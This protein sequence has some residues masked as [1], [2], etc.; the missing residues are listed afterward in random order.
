[1]PVY[2]SADLKDD[3]L[4]RKK[5]ADDAK[6][7]RGEEFKLGAPKTFGHIA[8]KSLKVNEDKLSGL[9]ALG[10]LKADVDNLGLLMS[11][12]LKGELST[13]S[14]VATLS[15]QINYYF[16]IYLPYLLM[17]EPEFNDVYTVFAGG[18]DLFL[19]GPW[20]RIIT[21]S[22]RINTSFSEYVC[23]NLNIHL[24]AGI[25]VH[26]PNTPMGFMA[27]SAESGLEEAKEHCKN[28]LTVFDETVLWDEMAKL[29]AIQDE[30]K[31]WLDKRWINAAM[32]YRLN[33]IIE[34]AG[35]E[36][37]IVANKNEIYLEDMECTK[38][39][40]LLSYSVGRNAAKDLKPEERP[41][42][43]DTVIKSLNN[44]LS[45]YGSKLKIPVWNMLYN[46]RTTKKITGGRSMAKVDFWKDDKKESIDP[47]LFSSKAEN[48]A[49][50]IKKES[51]QYKN[52]NKRTQIRK[53]YD[54]VVRLDVE[55][56]AREKEWHNIAPLVHMLTAKAAY[57]KGRNLISQG[58]S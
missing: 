10:V 16:S 7:E 42:V 38:W 56:K 6:L 3:R 17:T 47:T 45:E 18:D 44:W 14:R 58:F 36:N 43:I 23:K 34:M 46:R 26:K 21:L 37:R 1:M 29:T 9:E 40:A 49:L 13:L 15:R 48:L 39:R 22:E 20:N 50:E 41:A 5:A 8:G 57:A 51:E 53:F 32:L 28:R 30:L 55:A 54:E 12:G 25:S 33:Q 19:I 11:C 35:V 2:T 52:T 4:F 31:T 24:S 27:E